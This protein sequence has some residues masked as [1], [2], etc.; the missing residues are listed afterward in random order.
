MRDDEVVELDVLAFA[1]AHELQR[2]GV[3]RPK[4]QT[5]DEATR[6]NQAFTSSWASLVASRR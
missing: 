6:T 1:N 3:L 4:H 2:R 5:N